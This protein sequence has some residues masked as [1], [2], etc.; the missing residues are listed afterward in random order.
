MVAKR[1]R[2]YEA[3][4]VAREYVEKFHAR[5]VREQHKFDFDW[6]EQLQHVG[7]SL[8][9]AYASDKWKKQ[10]DY[11]LYKHLAESPN[12]A[13]VKRGLL[14]EWDDDRKVRTIGP[15][16][17]FASVPLPQH[18]AILGFFEESNFRL[19]T[20][21]SA[22]S[23]KFSEDEDDGCVAVAIGDAM[24]G[25]SKILWSEVQ[26]GRPDQPFLFVYTNSDG[27][28]MIIT[29]ETLDVKR[30]GIVG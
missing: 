29:G 6:P 24:L 10:G 7:D 19:H 4:D 20:R 27:P 28:L 1:K 11:E 15:M 21:G 30:D 9:V 3:N 8:A 26:P 25:A 14:R 17:S 18:F 2:V 13:Y 16:I 23:P 12:V 22:S 5:P